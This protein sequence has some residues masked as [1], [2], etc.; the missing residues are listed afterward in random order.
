MTDKP[1]E[2]FSTICVLYL[3]LLKDG[4]LSFISVISNITVFSFYKGGV[5]SSEAVKV[6]LKI[7]FFSLSKAP[8]VTRV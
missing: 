2:L 6:K 3:F 7:R 1:G 4:A 5:P 8:S